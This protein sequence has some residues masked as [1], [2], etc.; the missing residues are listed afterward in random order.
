MIGVSLAEIQQCIGRSRTST[1]VVTFA[2]LRGLAALLDAQLTFARVGEPIPPGWHWL[3]F[4]LTVPRSALGPDGAETG[5]EFLPQFALSQRMWAGGTFEFYRALHIGEPIKRVSTIQAIDEKSGKHGPLIFVTLRHEIFGE[6]DLAIREEQ[7]L[8]FRS[9]LAS[10][11]RTDCRPA[12]RNPDWSKEVVPNAV[13]LFRFSALT[14]N[15]HRIHYDRRYA[16]EVEGYPGLVIHGPLQAILL[17]EL[18]R[19][20][21]TKPLVA[22]KYRLLRPLFDCARIS[23]NGARTGKDIQVWT[24]DAAGN[25][26]LLGEARE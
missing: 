5:G 14:F 8:A 12:P 9:P 17:L 13:L 21:L 20:V 11:Q 10:G 22:F 2:P 26:G 24:A 6:S 7:I 1:D 19:G 16:T 25:V 4:L 23:V 3:Y 18:L 15:A